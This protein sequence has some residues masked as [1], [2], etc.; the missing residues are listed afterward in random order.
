MHDS[1]TY[2]WKS[3]GGFVQTLEIPSFAQS[4]GKCYAITATILHV[5]P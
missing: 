4:I 5:S 2:D 1:V 3:I